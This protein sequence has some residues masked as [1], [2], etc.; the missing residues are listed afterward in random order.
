VRK[1]LLALGLTLAPVAA[2]ADDMSGT[3]T[4]NAAFESMGVTFTT[5]CTF[6]QDAAGNLAGPCK[7]TADEQTPASGALRTGM[8]GKP[9]VDFGYDTNY[10][11]TPVHLE[12]VGLPQ[13]DGSL[14]GTIS[15]HGAQGTFTATRK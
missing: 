5:T 8:S 10:E 2:L 7:G 15:A 4:I 11:G 1:L 9:E 3:W 13:A 12:Y 6:K 14:T